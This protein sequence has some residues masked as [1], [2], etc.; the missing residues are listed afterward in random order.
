MLGQIP[1]VS[2]VIT[3]AIAFVLSLGLTPLAG[4]LGKRLGLVDEPGG[5]HQHS[6]AVPRP[7]GIALYLAFMIAV[8]IAQKLPVERFDPAEIIRLTGL[9]MG[10]TFIFLFGLYDDW[11]ELKP[12]P[13]FV[14]Q[15]IAAAIAIAFLIF[16]ESVNNPFNNMQTPRFP[17]A[18]TVTITLL[19][20]GLMMNTVNWLDGLD[21]LSSGV[22]VIACIVLFVN[23]AFR[24]NPPQMSV[25]LLPIALGG[26]A[27]GF[28][29]FNFHPARI[30]MGTSGSLFLGFTL[31][32]LS[33]IGGAKMATILLVMGLPLLDF[34]WQI[35]DRLRRGQNPLHADRGH[36]HFRLLDIGIS[37]RKIVI[38]YYAFLRDLRC[39][40]AANLI[41]T[42]QI[43]CATGNGAT[44]LRRIR[45]T[46]PS[47][48]CAPTRPL[49]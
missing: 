41:T 49:Y 31:G 27:L 38:G 36:L 4:L 40:G 28:L 6:H 14:A 18:V 5:R 29:P 11:R 44:G 12:L 48:R 45:A 20:L 23:S 24:L 46:I 25:A 15:L 8:L 33:I 21:G 42:L 9:L 30:F 43:D 13:Q 26:A 7:G 22:V 16:I 3:F 32:A 1:A 19:W 2:F 17:Y 47:E 35:I 10:A 39:A 37:Q 34:A